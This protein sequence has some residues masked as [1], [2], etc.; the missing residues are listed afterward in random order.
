MGGQLYLNNGQPPNRTNVC[1]SGYQRGTEDFALS[2]F[3]DN[4]GKG[5]DFIDPDI[6][7]VHFQTSEHYLHFQKIKPEHKRDYYDTWKAEKDPLTILK[8]ITE[9]SSPYYI[10]NDHHAYMNNNVFNKAWDN[11]KIFVQMQINAAKYQQSKEFRNSIQKSIELGDAFGDNKGPAT[12]IEDTSSLK[13]GKKVEE[14][15]GTGPGGKGKNILGNSQTA[16]AMLIKN[17]QFDKNSPMPELK[18]FK[19]TQVAGYYANA[20]TQYQQGVQVALTDVRKKSG[21]DQGFN[22]PDTSDLSPTLVQKTSATS[23]KNK[24]Q[25][26]QSFTTSPT[27]PQTHVNHHNP[28]QNLFS[29]PQPTYEYSKNRNQ[30]LVIQNNR[31]VGYEFRRS[32]N[33]NWEKSGDLRQFQG[34]VDHFNQKRQRRSPDLHDKSS[35]IPQSSLTSPKSSQTPPKKGTSQEVSS[36]IQEMFDS[37]SAPKGS[38][39]PVVSKGG[40]KGT[41]K[42]AF[43]TAQ[44]AQTFK[45]LLNEFGFKGVSYYG[46]GEKYPM[47]HNG[48][49][50][51]HIVRFEND[52]NKATIPTEALDFLRIKLNDDEKVADIVEQMGFDRP[53]LGNRYTF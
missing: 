13:A 28:F 24:Q 7:L 31:I 3:D 47:Q 5:Y 20:Q 22:Q 43:D 30:R 49:E 19:T 46:A 34:L 29:P 18:T 11:D 40:M 14:E 25:N 53:E 35:S 9:Q 17:K 38:D 33:S 23:I 52:G 51:S 44:D 36:A 27:P 37:K 10:P 21:K 8:G 12:I 41:F 2:N 15:W 1:V 45:Q 39:I 42:M 50:L 26:A 16:F 6:G 48:R 4:N 32:S